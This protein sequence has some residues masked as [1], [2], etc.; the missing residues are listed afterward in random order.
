MSEIT[1]GLSRRSFL[2]LGGVAALGGAA[3]LAGCA[4]Q[5]SSESKS[6][7]AKGDDAAMKTADQTKECDIAVVGAGGAGMWAAVEAVRAGKS[8]VVI[9]KGANVGVA[10]GSLAGGPFIVGSKLQQEAGI[11]FTV[12]EAFNHIMEYG[13]W[14]TN[15]AAIKAAVEISGE[16]IDQFTSDFG[17]PTGLRPDNY[18]AGHASVRANFQADPKDSKTQAKGEARM[19]PLQEFVESE[20]G[21]FLFNTAGKRLIMENGAC[22]GVQCEGEG[23]ID[24]KAKQVIV[25]TG[26]FLGSADMMLEKF[27]TFVNPLGNILSVGEGIDMVQAAGG[28]VSTQWGIAGNEF[29]GSN[30]KADGLYDRKNAAFTVGIYGT[31]LVNNQGRRFSNEGKFA[32]LPLALG[33]AISLVGG[34]YY[35]VVDQTY[36]D[37][38]NAGTDAWTLCGSDAE[39]WRTGMMT[40]KGKA[41]ENVQANFDAAVEEGWAFKADSIEALAEAIDAPDLAKTVETY[42]AACAAGKDDQFYKPACFLQPVAA[43]PFYAM[44]Y[45]PSAWVTIGG[46]RTNDRLQAIDAEGVAIPGLYVAGADNGTLMSAPYTDYEGYSLMCAYCGGRLAGQYAAAA[47]DA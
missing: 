6:E 35:A 46:I 19:K 2:T 31:L 47:I 38:L 14:S 3:A 21:E 5:A 26:G 15:A 37:G 32:N 34:K 17:V 23:V 39:N 12:E 42:N 33:G 25:A 30:Q 22:V 36:V 43:G 40:L 16:T 11:D 29:A 7:S 20:G 45:E 4:P 9:E 44:Q 18:G 10:N 1:K 28:Q 24:V 8:V 41:L 27:G 13:H